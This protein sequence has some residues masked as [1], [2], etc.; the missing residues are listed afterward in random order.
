MSRLVLAPVLLLALAGCDRL[1][2]LD[3]L[4]NPVVAQGIFVGL[5]LPE[6]IDLSDSD[7]LAYSAACSVFLADVNDPSELD[8]S[9]VEGAQ[10]AF[11]SVQNNPGLDLTDA[12]AGK[13]LVSADNGLVYVPGD[14]AV[15][16]TELGGEAVRLSVHTPAA[17]DV[18]VPT[19]LQPEHGFSVDL[20]GQ[21]YDN[22]LVAVY[23]ITRN[24]LTYDNL[25]TD[26]SETYN[27]THGDGAETTVI[28]GEA[29][30]RQSNYVVGIAGV[31]QADATSFEGVSQTLSAFMAG[32]FTLR[33]VV[34]KD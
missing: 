16:T 19:S 10:I 2:D 15:I 5:D 31:T 9:P 24:K 23:D 20:T 11:R 27:F 25:P 30:L 4:A 22:V 6:G 14:D 32:Q 13:Y 12:G 3:N 8:N 33:F 7:L 26:I 18:D 29:F 21:G 1:K 28:P 34:V 17:P